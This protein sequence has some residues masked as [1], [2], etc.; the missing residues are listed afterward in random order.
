MFLYFY[1]DQTTET[2]VSLTSSALPPASILPVVTS[3]FKVTIVSPSI[4]VTESKLELQIRDV[5]SC[6]NWIDN[7]G[8]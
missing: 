8:T 7:Y 6:N 3:T 1:I 4:F 2:L 5:C